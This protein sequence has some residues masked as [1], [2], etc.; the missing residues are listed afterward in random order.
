MIET[1]RSS[2]T[3]S[4]YTLFTLTSHSRG[5][6][7]LSRYREG[8]RYG[9]Q[10]LFHE[11]DLPYQRHDDLTNASRAR[12]PDTRKKPLRPVL[13][14]EGCAGQIRGGVMGLLAHFVQS[15]YHQQHGSE[16]CVED[17]DPIQLTPS[18]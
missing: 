9:L 7:Q 17:P 4:Q 15:F 10:G 18:S 1:P 2:P 14:Q 13:N 12:E 6:H 3:K 5:C 16:G 8:R 11:A